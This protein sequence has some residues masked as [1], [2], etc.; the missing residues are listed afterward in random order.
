MAGA[1][2]RAF[3]ER[4]IGSGAKKGNKIPVEIDTHLAGVMMFKS[5]P[6]GTL[7][8]SFDVRRSEVPRIEIYG[9][10]AALSVPDPNTFGG[11]VRIS[12]GGDWEDVP[13]TR[14]YAEN[15]RG[16]G[17]ADLA[18]AIQNGRTAR[19]SG[20]LAYHVLDTM[21]TFH[22]LGKNGG[23]HVLKSTVDRPASLPAS[24]KEHEID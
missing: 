22:D 21:L 20:D 4:E 9:T 3:E 2:T 8:T 17:V 15:S 13:L 16:L 7:A 6:I 11:P 18:S 23:H 5:G 14:A 24:L 12:K 10:K 19:A 1:S